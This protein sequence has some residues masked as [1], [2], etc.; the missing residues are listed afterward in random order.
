MADIAIN[1]VVRRVQFTGNTGLGPFAFTFNILQNTD[2]I[3]YKNTTLLTLTTDYTVTINANG[4]GSVTLTGSGSGTALITTDNL[5]II[6]GRELSRTTDFVT[7][8]DLLASS[9]NEQLDSNVIMSQQLDERFS[10]T[11]SVSPGDADKTLTL[12]TVDDRKDKIL[13][14]DTEGNVE[15][16]AA[17]TVFANTVV[18]ANFT[19]NVFTGDGSTVAFTTT[20]A[21]GSKN[22]CQVYID[23][24]YQEKASFSIN[25]TTLTFTEAPP[26]NASIEV[27]I[28]N[29]IETLDADSGNINYNQGGTGAQTRTVESKLQEFVSVKDFGA[30]GDGVADDTAAI[31]NAL[32]TGSNIGIMFEGGKTYKVTSTLT[33]TGDKLAIGSTNAIKFKFSLSSAT[34]LFDLSGTEDV[35]TTTLAADASNDEKYIT[36]TSASGVSV[37]QLVT[38]KSSAS[39]HYDPRPLTADVRKGEIHIVT[40]IDG[41]NIYL[42]GVVSDNYVVASETVDVNFHDPAEIKLEDFIVEYPRDTEVSSGVS[43]AFAINSIIKNVEV[44]YSATSGI[45]FEASVNCLIDNC[46][47]DWINRSGTGY[48]VSIAR[49]KGIIVRNSH[50]NQCRAGVDFTGQIPSRHCLVDGCIVQGGGTASDGVTDMFSSGLQRG[51]GTHGGSEHVKFTNN[52]ISKVWNGVV[53]RGASCVI[54]NNQ[55][56]GEMKSCVSISYGEDVVITGNTHAPTDVRTATLQ[57]EIPDIF[58]RFQTDTIEVDGRFDISNN[59][60]MVSQSFIEINSDTGSF[61]RLYASNNRCVIYGSA[62]DP[63]FIEGNYSTSGNSSFTGESNIRDNPVSILNGASFRHYKDTGTAADA[64]YTRGLD[65]FLFDDAS[66]LEVVSGGSLANKTVKLTTSLNDGIATVV[67]QVLFDVTGSATQIRIVDLPPSEDN[68]VY[69][70]KYYDGS[71][72]QEGMVLIGTSGILSIGSS[73]ASHTGTFSVATGQAVYLNISYD[74]PY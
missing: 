20:V 28:G 68:T 25:A 56:F 48:G 55:F 6:G 22:N 8:G 49:S 43:G 34:Q 42:D 65:A 71:A 17:S 47:L 13:K 52:Q 53:S 14:F 36:V 21:A 29:A 9:L 44:K 63:A 74:S 69:N 70:I 64:R 5:T 67:G 61:T 11:I 62:S 41:T 45:G 59:Y 35:A 2:I 57:N 4:T 27:I 72:Y 30:V 19:N 26:L 38:L 66:K 31:Q 40:E 51:M 46:K 12:P 60:S 39:W 16:A 18:G 32:N 37:G 3:V 58:V 7:A 24:V 10:R 1:P 15:A 33:W 73:T 54:Q 23:G 50:F